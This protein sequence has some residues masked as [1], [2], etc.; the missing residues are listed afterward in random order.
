MK[1][2]QSGSVFVNHGLWYYS[3]KL[4]GE[5]TRRNVPLK[6]PNSNHTLPECRTARW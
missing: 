1:L 3:V 4:P 2:K 5:K 6:A